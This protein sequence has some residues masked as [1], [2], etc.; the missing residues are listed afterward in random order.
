[1]KN[2][3]KKFLSMAVLALAGAMMS[4]CGNEDDF[5]NDSKQQ[6]A[7]VNNVVTLTTTVGLGGGVTNR[8]MGEGATNRALAEGGVK[9]FGE[10]AG[11]DAPGIDRAIIRYATPDFWRADTKDN[12]D[13]QKQIKIEK[14][15][16]GFPPL[17]GIVAFFYTMIHS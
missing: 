2:T 5:A 12:P 8:A 3:M 4:G 15:A 10:T 6:P 16:A 13:C 14:M 1:M 9:T 11:S 17:F 7:N